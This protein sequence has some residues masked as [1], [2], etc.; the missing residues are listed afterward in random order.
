MLKNLGVA[1][2][3][4]LFLV[5]GDNT[6]VYKSARNLQKANV[7]SAN[8]LNTYSILNAETLIISESTAS[9]FS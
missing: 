4:T 1:D 3:K 2:K 6:N 9:S 8:L 5:N 7:M